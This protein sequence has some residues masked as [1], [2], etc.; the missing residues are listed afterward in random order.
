MSKA[1]TFDADAVIDALSPALGLVVDPASRAGVAAYLRV[2]ERMSRVVQAAPVPGD[3]A[4]LA[5]VFRPGRA[6][7]MA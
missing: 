4:E 3:E 2:A 5:P 7:E 6:G 1:E